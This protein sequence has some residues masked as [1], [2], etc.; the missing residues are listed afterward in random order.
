MGERG[1]KKTVD[2][3]HRSV[4]SKRNGTW[5]MTPWETM[6]RIEHF[7]LRSPMEIEIRSLKKSDELTEQ[8]VLTCFSSE[9]YYFGKGL[10]SVEAQIGACLEFVERRLGGIVTG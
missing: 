4:K 1:E 6:E 5:S 8:A 10:N 9:K 2:L 3:S 7:F